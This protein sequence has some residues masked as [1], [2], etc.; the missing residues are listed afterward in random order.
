MSDLTDCP[1]NGRGLIIYGELQDPYYGGIVSAQGGQI[2]PASDRCRN[3][4]WIREMLPTV[5]A[6]LQQVLG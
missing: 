1:L 4:E 5:F 6:I 3:V 2:Q